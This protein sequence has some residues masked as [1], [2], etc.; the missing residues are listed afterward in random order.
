MQPFEDPN[1]TFV[2]SMTYRSTDTYRMSEIYRQ[3]SELKKMSLKREAEKKDL[4]DIV[5]QDKLVEVRSKL[6]VSRCHQSI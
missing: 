1:A 4:A 2:K 6:F 3:I 5:E